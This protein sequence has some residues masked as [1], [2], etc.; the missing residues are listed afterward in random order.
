MHATGTGAALAEE[1]DRVAHVLRPRRAVQADHVDAERLE[2][3]QDR[4]DVGPEQHLA[5]VRQQ[6]YGGVD[7]EH[8]ALLAERLAGAE[9]RRLDLE[10]VLRRLDDQQV[11]AA[12]DQ[13]RGLLG[14]H[15]DELAEADVPEPR[16]LRRRK[17]AGGTDRSGHEAALAGRPA[18]DLRRF[19]VDLHRVVGQAPLLELDPRA[20]EGVGLHDL[21]SRFEHRGVDA[22]DHVGAVQDERLVALAGQAAVVLAR[23][24]EL[25][26]GRAHAAV[27]DDD[28][29]PDRFQVVTHSCEPNN[30]DVD[31]WHRALRGRAMRSVQPPVDGGCPLGTTRV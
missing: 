2:R 13:A 17:V 29:A 21:G 8:A 23:Q 15:G 16:L 30:E 26:E 28:P 3:G 6:R 14:E 18:R 31:R 25:L 10:D 12:L 4:R 5:A 7:R 27:V 19:D 24:L 22:L 9:D 20:L 1:A 11:C